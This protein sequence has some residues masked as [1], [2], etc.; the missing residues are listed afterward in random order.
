MLIYRGILMVALSCL[1][2][3]GY[4][5]SIGRLAEVGPVFVAGMVLL[6]IA[7]RGF[8]PVKGLAFTVFILGVTVTSLYYP[9]LFLE[10]NGFELATL[11][12]PLI[13][14]I[15]FGTGC[16]MGVKD[17]IALS[18]SPKSVIVG[19]IAQYTVMPVMSF[20]LANVLGFPSEIA[21]GLILLGCASTSV[22]ASLFSFLA[23]A[24]VALAITITSITTL[25]A[26]LLIPFLMKL[27]AGGYI[28]I[29]VLGM[30]WSMMKMVLLPI[31]AGLLFNKLTSGKAKWLQDA[32]PYVSMVGIILIN[33]II[34]ASGRE[35]ILTIGLR[36]LLAVLLLL[37]SG[38]IFGYW[39]GRLLGLDEKDCRTIAITTGMQNAGMVSGIA[40]VMGKVG[41]LGLASAICGPLMGLP[42]SMLASYWG[43]SAQE[44][45]P[46][47]P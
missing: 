5:M 34:I 25:M 31:G 17:F 27:F 33:A 15:M 7:F 30:L 2:Y 19:V 4:Q 35:S 46:D 1:M 26:P 20:V 16:S 44:K 24:N 41:T 22:T 3:T 6:S 11:I 21:A 14:I 18:K 12:T 28:E 37:I 8:A 47:E 23:K 38:F 45:T 10:I 40:K 32:M 29:D 42:A 39:I 9:G 43:S 13:Q 36:L